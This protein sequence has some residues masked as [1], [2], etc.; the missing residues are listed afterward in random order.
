MSP[1][2]QTRDHEFPVCNHCDLRVLCRPAG[3]GAEPLPSRILKHRQ[4]VRRGGYVFRMGQPC[5]SL[6]AICSGSARASLLTP[7]G[8]M[9]VTGF[10]FSGDL[11]GA[12][13][14][15]TREHRCDVMAIEPV[16]VCEIAIHRLEEIAER[17]P[18]MQRTLLYLLS[19]ELTHSQE[20]LFAFLGKKSAMARLA[21]YLS[22]VARRLEQRGLPPGQTGLQMSRGDL[23][24]Y[25]GLAKE[26][27]SR[28]FTRFEDDGLLRFEARRFWVRDPARLHELAGQL[29][30]DG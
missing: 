24:S 29:E 19:N 11:I 23:G 9:Q 12:E 4:Q 1:T 15:S 7:D 16:E 21:A 8:G 18:A 30:S 5:H 13:A 22:G 10:H 26:T 2:S 28:L 20:L 17:T 3:H 25:L 27:V 14:L 6:Y